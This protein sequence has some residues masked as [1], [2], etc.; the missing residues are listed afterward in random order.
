MSEPSGVRSSRAADYDR[1]QGSAIAGVIGGVVLLAV[2]AFLVSYGDF[3]AVA[4]AAGVSPRLAGLYPLI[5]DAA[6]VV[7]CTSLLALRGAAWWMRAYAAICYLIL[8]AAV[9][10]TGAIRA[11]GI[12]LPERGTAA[13][14]A[15]MPW[16]LFLLGFGLGLSLLKHRRTVRALGAARDADGRLR[17]GARPAF[18]EPLVPPRSREPVV[19]PRSREPKADPRSR[20]PGGNPRPRGPVTSPRPPGPVVNP[21]SREP[22]VR[23]RAAAPAPSLDADLD[24]PYVRLIPAPPQPPT[25]DSAGTGDPQPPS[26]A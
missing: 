15:A 16:L 4:V 26:S 9:A 1:L 17:P 10:V 5:F 8:V 21:R 18:R 24:E 7:A 22:A 20:E 13:T 12:G 11:A 19:P 3:H 25:G 6:L 14:L 23:Q 2:A